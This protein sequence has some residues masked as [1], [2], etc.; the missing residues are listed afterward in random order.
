MKILLRNWDGKYYVWMDAKYKNNKFYIDHSLYGELCMDETD[1]LAVKDDNRAGSVICSYCGAVIKDDP[2]SIE[3]HFAAEEAKRDC[4][5]CG[6]MR[7]GKIVTTKVE[8]DKNQ[9]NDY[10]V[11]ETYVAKLTCGRQWY[12]STSIDSEAAKSICKFYRCRNSGVKKIKDIFTEY[13]DPFDKHATVDVLSEKGIVCEGKRNDFFEYDLK[14]RN[15][16]KAYVNELGII[17]H[18]CIKVRNHRYKAYYS[19]KYDKLFF[20]FN[21]TYAEDMPHDMSESKYS[22]AKAKIAALYKEEKGK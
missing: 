10:V 6:D 13:P 12:N 20:N 7:R 18:F 14:V 22:A 21:S 8:Y 15:T 5:K 17:D 16:V 3:A 1:I 2:E 19:A 11:T 4:F 9:N